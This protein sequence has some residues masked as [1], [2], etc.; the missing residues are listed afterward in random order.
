MDTI[1][2]SA[3]CPEIRSCGAHDADSTLEKRKDLRDSQKK[4]MAQRNPG[5]SEFSHATRALYYREFFSQGL[6]VRVASARDGD[7]DRRA[8]GGTKA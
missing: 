4:K 1:W 7:F 3:E 2:S 5:D 6:E 8:F